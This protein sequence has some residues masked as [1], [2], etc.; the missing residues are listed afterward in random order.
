M[1]L[2][3]HGLITCTLKR[4]GFSLYI[5]YCIKF[6]FFKFCNQTF[7]LGILVPIKKQLALNFYERVRLK[8]EGPKWKTCQTWV[9]HHEFRKNI[10]WS[11]NLNNQENYTCVFKTKWTENK[12]WQKSRGA[13]FSP[14]IRAAILI[15]FQYWYPSF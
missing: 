8:K 1:H 7:F 4:V 9:T 10:F 5:Y 13:V 6:V 15:V 12:L 11:F 2:Y 14:Y 3:F